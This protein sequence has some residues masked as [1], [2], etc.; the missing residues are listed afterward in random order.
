MDIKQLTYF[1]HVAELG[2]FTRA[3]QMLSIAQPAI[4]RQIGSL[5]KELNKQLFERHG[6]G[7]ILTEAGRQLLA[8]A[9]SILA[10]LERARRDVT[11]GPTALTGACNVGIPPSV[12]ALLTLPLVSE[13]QRLFP[14]AQ[15]VLY[16]VL[17][18]YILEWLAQGRIDVGL[19]YNVPPSP[20]YD[21]TP[22][23]SEEFYLISPVADHSSGEP[24]ELPELA[25]YPFI[26][27]SARHVRRFL[28]EATL[29]KADIEMRIACEVGS[30]QAILDLVHAG[31]GYAILPLSALHNRNRDFSIRPIISPKIETT[32]SLLTPTRR[33][34]TRLA[35][36]VAEIITDVLPNVV[37]R[38]ATATI[39][40]SAF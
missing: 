26:V 31:F 5:E 3:E 37:E 21:A 12:G 16:E 8:H 33:P 6:R 1:L 10:Q 32:L 13:F 17:S 22:V 19:A 9:H 15:L 30:T 27:P 2:S 29:S 40:S 28:I 18:T 39:T 25:K 20:A 38:A 23:V 35:G 4:S 34:L 7:V 11:D 36:R 14:Q 24:I